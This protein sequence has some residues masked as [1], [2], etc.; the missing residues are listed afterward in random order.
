MYP[1]DGPREEEPDSILCELFRGQVRHELDGRGHQE[2]CRHGDQVEVPGDGVAPESVVDPGQ[3]G[4]EK[5]KRNS[6]LNETKN[7]IF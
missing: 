5:R 3:V 4:G 2:E 1:I 7:K 6:K